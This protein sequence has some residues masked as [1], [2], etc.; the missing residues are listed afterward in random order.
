MTLIADITYRNAPP[1]EWLN[2][3]IQRRVARLRTY[4]ADLQSCKVL[5]EIPHRHH[6]QGNHFRVRIDLIVPGDKIVVG[7]EPSPGI[8]DDRNRSQRKRTEIEAARK[9]AARTFRQAFSVAK[10]ELQEYTRRRR[11]EIK[12][13]RLTRHAPASA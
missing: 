7:H 4:C 1:S 9:D 5:V 3:A 6:E 13:H 11:L 10:R 8:E 12:T 2:A